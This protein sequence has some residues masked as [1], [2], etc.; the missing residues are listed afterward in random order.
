[1]FPRWRFRF[2]RPRKIDG[3][4]IYP[5]P[6]EMLDETNRGNLS[7]KRRDAI[8]YVCQRAGKFVIP[9]A[10]L[11][12]FDLD[13]QQLQTIDFPARTITVARN[14]AMPST[15][16]GV[17]SKTDWRRIALISLGSAVGA[18]LLA[19]LFWRT[20]ALWR[21]VIDA[22]RPVHLQPLNP[23]P[24]RVIGANGTKVP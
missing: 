7:G 18:C 6:P 11:N 20:R 15:P 16:T 10:R 4:G 19:L 2:F 22:F 23:R 21:R 12:W 24:P 3:I 14:P 8:T 9:A 13:A 17:A 5:K 1:M